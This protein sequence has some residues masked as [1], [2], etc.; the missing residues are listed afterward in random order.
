MEG[1]AWTARDVTGLAEKAD[2]V[3][4][5]ASLHEWYYL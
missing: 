5:T 1:S 4:T 3:Y 2:A